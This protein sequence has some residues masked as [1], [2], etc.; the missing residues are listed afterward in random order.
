MI[1]LKWWKMSAKVRMLRPWTVCGVLLFLAFGLSQARALDCAD[2]PKTTGLSRTIAIDSTNGKKFGRLQYPETVPLRTKEVVLTFDDGPSPVHTKVILDTLDKYCVKA[3]FFTVGRMALFSPKVLKLVAK[4]GHT[5]ASHTWSH[6]RDVGKLPIEEAK[7]EIEKGFAASSHALGEPI[8]P[9]FRFPGLN[10]S[11]ELLTYLKS[12][13]IS[14]WSVDVVSGDTTAGMTPEQLFHD[15]LERL[16]KMGKGVILFHDLKAVTAETLDSFLATLR[17]EGFKIVHVVSNS[18]Y[19]PNPELVARL[20][21]EKM[22]LQSVAFTG[23][24]AGGGAGTGA[25]PSSED[26][27]AGGEVE[28][29]KTEFMQIEA[30]ALKA[31]QDLADSQVAKATGTTTATTAATTTTATSAP[32]AAVKPPARRVGQ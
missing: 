17:A 2:D 11:P 4:R 7:L 26:Y 10:D 30:S 19:K 14:V 25:L 29:M 6:P 32:P 15:T 24:T 12:R 16:R 5:I 18:S 22:P 27:L 1:H 20:Q 13:D 31:K 3:T 8:A 9:F 21:I 23:E 28:I